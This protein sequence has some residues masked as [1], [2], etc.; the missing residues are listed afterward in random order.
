MFKKTLP[1]LLALAM[2]TTGCF[3]AKKVDPQVAME[4]MV[5]SI[6]KKIVTCVP[7]AIPNEDFCKNT[8]KEQISSAKKMPKISATQKDLD[9]CIAAIDQEPCEAATTGTP[10]SSCDFLK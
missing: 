1:A 2:S 4:T 10:P 8:M 9:T 3:G 7:N 6:C 5:A